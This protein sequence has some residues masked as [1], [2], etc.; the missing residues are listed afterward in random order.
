[1]KQFIK[2]KNAGMTGFLAPTNTGENVNYALG[3]SRTCTGKSQQRPERCAS[4]NS[5]TRATNNLLDIVYKT[6]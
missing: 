6:S 3:R 1:M 2:N 5:A 4:A